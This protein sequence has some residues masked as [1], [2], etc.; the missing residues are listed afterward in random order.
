MSE[1]RR[2][3]PPPEVLA[4]YSAFPE[5]SRLTAGLGLLEGERTR[6]L[7]Q[8][9]LPPP[10]ARVLDVGGAA[11]TYAF[12]LAAQGYAVHLIDA[13][14]R[15]VEAALR[16]N[17]TAEHKL[18]RVTLGDARELPEAD[19][20]ADAVLVLGPLYH[21]TEHH[22]RLRALGEARRV[23]RPGG[24]LAASAVC[25]FAA[26]LDGLAFHPGLDPALVAMRQR[27]VAD[28]QYRNQT[29]NLNYFVT[30]YFHR[31]EDLEAELIAAAFDDVRVFAVEGPGSLLA[32]FE[33]RWNDPAGRQ[34]IL[35]AVRLLEEE[36]SL[37]GASAHLLA[38]G[39]N[40]GR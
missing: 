30:A 14:P 25:R 13:T 17:D 32:N 9:F 28:G 33:A 38:F 15:L 21:L 37:T 2:F 35:A 34:E 16:R 27:S 24:V 12:W 10:P 11:G 4:Y 39:T 20:A 8:R 18:A 19:G 23:A 3:E 40:P 5:P 29:N 36:R 1:R 7:L 6:E 22:D 26:V 31:P